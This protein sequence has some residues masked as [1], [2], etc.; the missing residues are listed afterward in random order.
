MTA[1]DITLT[2][3]PRANGFA[4]AVGDEHGVVMYVPG[5]ERKTRE[6]CDALI[7]GNPHVHPLFRPILATLM[8]SG[9]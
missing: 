2:V 5:S 1:T 3:V 7:T 4:V 6:E 9:S 8:G